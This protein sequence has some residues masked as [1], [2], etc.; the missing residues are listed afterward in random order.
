MSAVARKYMWSDLW[1]SALIIRKGVMDAASQGNSVQSFNRSV[2]SNNS[3]Q[4]TAKN[5]AGSRYGDSAYSESGEM[6]C[7]SGV[8]HVSWKPVRIV[9]PQPVRISD[10]SL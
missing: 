7:S 9:E 8:C 4:S 5:N 6:T 2:V 10:W 1:R 3:A